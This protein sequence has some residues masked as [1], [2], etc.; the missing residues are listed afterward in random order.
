M[1][2]TMNIDQSVELM[3]LQIHGL[4]IFSSATLVA[5]LVKVSKVY[6]P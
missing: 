6:I 4:S 2:S 3:T 5:F 1:K